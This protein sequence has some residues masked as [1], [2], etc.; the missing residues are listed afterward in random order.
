MI[1]MI[2]WTYPSSNTLWRTDPLLSKDLETNNEYSRCYAIDEETNGR[3]CA[4]A[5]LTRPAETR[6]TQQYSYNGNGGVFYVVRAEE[7]K[8]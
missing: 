5:R 6:R 2:I 7:L 1:L 8:K 4:T 3:F